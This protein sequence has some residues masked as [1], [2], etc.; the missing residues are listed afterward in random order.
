LKHEDSTGERGRLAEKEAKAKSVGGMATVV[1]CKALSSN[2]PTANICIYIYN[3]ILC[4]VIF[5]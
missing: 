4:F 1:K 3:I 2:S 5:N